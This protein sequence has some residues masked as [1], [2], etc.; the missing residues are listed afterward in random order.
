MLK[1]KYDSFNIIKKYYNISVII[2]DKR[3]PLSYDK[4]I[5]V[6]IIKC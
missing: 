4:N 6:E 2:L 5:K 1:Y 3:L